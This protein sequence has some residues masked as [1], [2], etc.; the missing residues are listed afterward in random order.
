[1]F[2]YVSRSSLKR[3]EMREFVEF[4]LSDEG[5]ELV[6]VKYIPLSPDQIA[7]SRQRLADAVAGL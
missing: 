4:Y 2:I 6:K 7:E 1:M 3:A 5:Q